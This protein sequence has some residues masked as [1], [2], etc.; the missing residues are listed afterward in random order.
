VSVSGHPQLSID[1]IFP[2]YL[3]VILNVHR[4]RDECYRFP[5]EEDL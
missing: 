4:V 3:C 2:T 5:L 1:H